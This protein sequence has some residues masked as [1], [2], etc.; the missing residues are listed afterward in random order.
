MTDRRSVQ[1]I[2]S[3][4]ADDPE[5]AELVDMFASELA[6]RM[7][8]VRRAV[9]SGDIDM[10]RT[11]AHQLKGSAA[12]YGFPSLGAVAASVESAAVQQRREEAD[13]E[14]LKTRVQELLELSQRIAN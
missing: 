6:D 5:M 9:E 4:F 1:P 3:E 14:T 13:T 12:G 7:E 10:V 2:K 11:I 8:N